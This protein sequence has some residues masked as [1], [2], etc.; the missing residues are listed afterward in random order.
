MGWNGIGIGFGF[1]S[2]GGFWVIWHWMEGILDMRWAL[3]RNGR[4]WNDG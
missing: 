3:G 1:G 2:K 4:K